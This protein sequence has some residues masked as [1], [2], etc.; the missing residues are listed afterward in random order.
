MQSNPRSPSCHSS[1]QRLWAVLALLHAG[2]PIWAL[3][4]NVAGLGASIGCPTRQRCLRVASHAAKESSL[5]DCYQNQSPQHRPADIARVQRATRCALEPS[6]LPGRLPC[7]T[8]QPFLLHG[9]SGGRLLALVSGCDPGDQLLVL[10]AGCSV[11]PLLF[12]LSP[13]SLTLASCRYMP[14]PLALPAGPLFSPAA[15]ALQLFLQQLAI[16]LVAPPTFPLSLAS[17]VLAWSPQQLLNIPL[18]LS[19]KFPEL[20]LPPCSNLHLGKPSHLW[21]YSDHT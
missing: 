5:S 18:H 16:C 8:G 1:C 15:A 11:P 21:C 4:Q 19:P 20:G 13:W 14:F 3:L 9:D 7:R 17:P 2:K 10:A 6:T 12:M